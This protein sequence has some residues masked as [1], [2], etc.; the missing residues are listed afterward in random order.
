MTNV[1]QTMIV[2][3]FNAFVVMLLQRI[4]VKNL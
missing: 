2:V 1:R 3:D 4:R